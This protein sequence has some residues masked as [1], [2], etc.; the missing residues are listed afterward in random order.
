[1]EDNKAREREPI[2]SNAVSDFINAFC[3]TVKPA[4]DV[5]RYTN[6]TE[7]YVSWISWMW[8]MIEIVQVEISVFEIFINTEISTAKLCL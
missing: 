6:V 2:F 4:F 1:L 5:I 3:M 7:L 8:D